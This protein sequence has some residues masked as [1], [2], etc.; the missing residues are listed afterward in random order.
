M[1]Q[2]DPL[3]FPV[4]LMT[5]LLRLGKAAQ[6]F[7]NRLP[8]SSFAIKLGLLQVTVGLLDKWLN[9]FASHRLLIRQLVLTDVKTLDI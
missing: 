2:A 1:F 5:V 9:L 6:G 3:I 7:G 4:L 8:W